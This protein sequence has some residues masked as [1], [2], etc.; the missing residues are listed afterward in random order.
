MLQLI[1]SR[2]HD[3]QR[4]ALTT[5]IRTKG[6]TPCKAGTKMLVFP[7][8]GTYGTIGGGCA[9]AEVKLKALSALD[10]GFPCTASVWLINDDAAQE[11]MICGGSMDVFIQIV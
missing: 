2:Q 8:G 1:I 9:E 4:T 11:G 10:D 6:S 3:G 7:D 5:I